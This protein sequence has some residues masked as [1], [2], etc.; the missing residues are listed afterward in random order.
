VLA[1][2][3]AGYLVRA[4]AGPRGAA[5]APPVFPQIVNGQATTAYPTTGAFLGYVDASRTVLSTLCSGTLIGCQT[6]LTAAHCVCA[7]TANDAAT[8]QREGVSDPAS[9][10]VFLQN[11]GLLD[12]AEVAVDPAYQFGVAGDVAV[13]RLTAPITG[14]APAAI[15]TTAKPSLG[16]MGTIVGFGTTSAGRGQTDDSG[17][18]RAG[19]V[20]T[21]GCEGEVPDDTQLCW[22][23]IGTESS[24]CEGDSGGPL[25]IE[26]GGLVLAGVSSGG[27]SAACTPPDLAFDTDVFG[28]HEWIVNQ[29]GADL[30]ATSCGALVPVDVSPT[31]VFDGSG[32]VSVAAPEARTAFTV[33]PGTRVLR[34]ALNG[35]AA[36]VSGP[37]SQD[38]DFDLYVR[39]GDPPTS[40][41]FDCRDVNTTAFGFCEIAAPVAGTWNVLV[42]LVQGQGAFQLTATA[43]AGA[44]APPCTGD[45]NGDGMV[46]VDE[47]L[48][49]VN[50]ALGAA[51]RSTCTAA[52][53]NSDG[54][55]TVD[56]LLAI[57]NDIL[58]DCAGG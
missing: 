29:A 31:S 50:I 14:I 45:C 48:T 7:E 6:F 25:F 43:F 15:N 18:K 36:T 38:N 8:C 27:V 46:T 24:T 39:A 21:A 33:P 58:N 9:L 53:A 41:A 56:E 34:F 23:Y 44:G 47:L 19:M 52:D 2:V 5:A 49:A 30:G 54:A 51:D 35:Q 26:S 12:V 13:L 20:T 17:L 11:G 42:Q 4:A 57:V 10:Q 1:A 40:A 22:Q 16:T 32:S 37:F 55:V 28:V 3:V